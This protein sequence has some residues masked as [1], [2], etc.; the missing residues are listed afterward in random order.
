MEDK[1]RNDDGDVIIILNSFLSFAFVDQLFNVSEHRK[2]ISSIYV[3]VYVARIWLSGQTIVL[4][5][6]KS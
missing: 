6:E 1:W 4:G 5:W 3:F 2:R